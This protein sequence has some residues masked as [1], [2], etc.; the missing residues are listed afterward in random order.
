MR[1][2]QENKI[3]LFFDRL[4]AVSF[5][6]LIFFLPISIALVEIFS[7]LSL[8]S[9]FCKRGSIFFISL[10]RNYSIQ[11]KLLS[12]QDMISLFKTS[13]KF[14]NN[15]IHRPLGFWIIISAISVLV[16]PYSKLSFTAFLGKNLQNAFIFFNFVEAISTKK[17]LKIFLCSLFI[18]YSIV[19]LSGINQYFFHQDFIRWNVLQQGRINS[20]FRAPNDFAAY[21]VMVLPILLNLYLVLNK[22]FSIA[23]PSFL[24]KK[25]IS[26]LLLKIIIFFMFLMSVYCLGLT[27]SR[28]AWL[29]FGFS[30]ISLGIC[31]RKFFGKLMVMGSIFFVFFVLKLISEREFMD[32]TNL[33]DSFG[34]E[35]YWR[36]A[37]TIIKDYPFFG[38]GLNAYSMVAKGY[39]FSWGGYPH[40]CYLQMAAE[41][42]LFGLAIFGWMIVILFKEAYKN[43]LE[44]KDPLW[45]AVFFGTVIGFGSFLI[46][47]FF[48]TFFYSVQ[49]GSL[50]WVIMG[51]IVAIQNIASKE[52]VVK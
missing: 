51:L 40:N 25:R 30:L 2:Y 22:N 41:M 27:F 35:S 19:C 34:R 23:I 8:I 10:L 9:Y 26:G 52:K 14:I 37:L 3:I 42:G 15:P 5:Y 43:F 4:M 16:S 46:H 36:E 31:S 38:V 28:G 29:A 47:S 21:I 17:R 45:K 44:I 24:S 49:L 1:K 20:C 48:D 13:F 18:S 32:K 12:I 50:M 11:H 33:F 6:V 7:V 39:H